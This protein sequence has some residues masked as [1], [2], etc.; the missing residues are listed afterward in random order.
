[1][2]D[3]HLRFGDGKLKSR[4]LENVQAGDLDPAHGTF[5]GI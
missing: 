3:C 1:M 2:S 5:L 4:L